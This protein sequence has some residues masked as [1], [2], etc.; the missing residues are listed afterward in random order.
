MLVGE[1]LGC[2]E[3]PL[4]HSLSPDSFSFF[5]GENPTA[6]AAG[7]YHPG[8]IS[9]LGRVEGAVQAFDTSDPCVIHNGIDAKPPLEI[10]TN[11][12]CRGQRTTTRSGAGKTI[13]RE[14]K[15]R[16]GTCVL[17]KLQSGHAVSLLF[18][19]SLLQNVKTISCTA[20][21]SQ[22][23]LSVLIVVACVGHLD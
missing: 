11:G 6:A 15:C 13:Y 21:D 20:H 2:G 22:P 16:R 14:K 5:P 8:H 9:G 23:S 1:F 4:I 7:F 19:Q 18:P 10:M 12:T 17:R 3:Q